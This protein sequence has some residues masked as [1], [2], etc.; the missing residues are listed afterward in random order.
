MIAGVSLVAA[1]IAVSLALTAHTKAVLGHTYAPCFLSAL[2]MAMTTIAAATVV[3]I[4]SLQKKRA[5]RGAQIEH[6]ASKN[7]GLVVHAKGSASNSIHANNFESTRESSA[8]HSDMADLKSPDLDETVGIMM[9]TETS[10]A[11]EANGKKGGE[12]GKGT[13]ALGVLMAVN[14]VVSNATLGMVPM[15]VHQAL[16]ALGPAVTACVA[17]AAAGEVP[18]R[19]AIAALVPVVVGVALCFVESPQTDVSV[20]GVAFTLFGVVLAA[21]KGVLTAAIV[22]ACGSSGSAS[23]AHAV[24]ETA[25]IACLCSVVFGLV[26]GEALAIGPLISNQRLHPGLIGHLFI[27]GALAAAL[28]LVGFAAVRHARAL[29]LSVAAN[30][31]TAIAVLVAGTHRPL[32]MIGAAIALSGALIYAIAQ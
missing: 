15:Y 8:N 5:C 24:L 3:L 29:G 1:Y 23:P 21:A 26:V 20:V 2:H 17:W 6:L 13:I 7:I 12:W 9:P 11:V 10:V 25:P 18:R 27:N 31:K 14:V 16:R 4:A 19:R 32:Q 28:N 30:A 22:R